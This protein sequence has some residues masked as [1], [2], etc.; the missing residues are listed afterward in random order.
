MVMVYMAFAFLV[1]WKFALLISFGG[2]LSNF[3]FRGIF[4][5]T[6]K[7]SA[8]STVL[9]NV[10][11]RLLIQYVHHFKY[12]RATGT[13]ELFAKKLKH[14]AIAV[15]ANNKR[16]GV[17]GIRVS[18]VREPILIAI[19]C[20]VILIQ[21]YYFKG[22]LSAVLISLLFFY[23][24]LSFL[25][26]MQ[27]NYNAFLASSGALANITEFENELM[28]GAEQNGD[29]VITHFQDTLELQQLFFKYDTSDYIL[30][31]ISLTLSKNQSIAFVGES[32][33]GKTTLVNVLSGLLR[34]TKGH[35][36]ID[37]HFIDAIDVNSY[38]KR[39]G[40]IAQEPV[41][42]NDTVFNNVTFWDD[43]T[44]E[45]KLRFYQALEQA[46][47][48]T[49]VKGLPK[50]E[51]ALL[52]NNGIN[53]SGGQRQRVSIARELYKTIDLLIL[54]EATSA[55]DSETEKEI[56]ENIDALK[57]KYTI[58]VIAHRLATIKN[59]D[60]IYFMEAGAITASGS[61]N[62]LVEKSARFKRMVELQEF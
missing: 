20:A 30:K 3:L 38:Q 44:E 24:S 31:D 17:L 16:M 50:Q 33:S 39:I 37:G 54:D 55:L 18:A 23:R 62:E 49:F 9:G 53:L 1:D 4:K 43:A 15:E 19:I 7:L 29:C 22:S 34:P 48:A 42:F 26:T 60:V 51:A 56:Q 6:K 8:T 12:L 11:Q 59:V 5:E 40:Y 27:S 52:G 41:I 21:V 61:F 45:N 10:F 25:M 14:T 46:S 32:G 36:L 47:L 57:G 58:V 35:L 2:V 13:S 28:E